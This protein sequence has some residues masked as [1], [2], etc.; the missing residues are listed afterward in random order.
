MQDYLCNRLYGLPEPEVERYL[1]QLCQLSIER[2]SGNSLERV[3]IDLCAQSLRI[4][5]KVGCAAAC[6][7]AA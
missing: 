7:G 4:A 3:I 5:V 2:P 6:V 1:A